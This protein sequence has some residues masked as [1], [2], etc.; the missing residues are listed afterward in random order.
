MNIQQLVHAT[1]VGKVVSGALYIHVSA[2]DTLPDELLDLIA[3]AAMAADEPDAT[4]IK[5]D[6]S[7]TI[8]SFLFYPTFDTD[9]HPPLH[10][11]VTVNLVNGKVRTTQHRSNRPILHRKE[12]FVDTDYP[13][14]EI[15]EALSTAE[16]DADL[17]GRSD[18]GR[19]DQWADVLNE[20]GYWIENHEL[21]SA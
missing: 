16:R 20:A 1:P 19:E 9:P 8:V 2:L 21:R 5:I 17:L 14:Y 13:N 11:A 6:R 7:G 12:T 10:Q 4:L 15:F 18:I 3:E